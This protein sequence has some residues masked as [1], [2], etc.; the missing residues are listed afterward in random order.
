MSEEVIAVLMGAAVGG[1]LTGFFSY[2]VGKYSIKATHR[3]DLELMRQQSHSNA[4]DNFINAFIE[5]L[6]KLEI[7]GKDAYVDILRPAF[8]KHKT[9]V[10]IFRQAIINDAKR[11][12]FD[13][14]WEEYYKNEHQPNDPL[15]QYSTTLQQ[16]DNFPREKRRPLAISRIKALLEFAEKK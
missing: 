9:A 4:C 14:A 13:K 12:A 16:T 2:M 5:E 6:V 8:Q 11:A 3:N 10:Y 1:L 15:R 7:E